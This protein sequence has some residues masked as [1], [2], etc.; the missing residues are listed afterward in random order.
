[1]ERYSNR[2]QPKADD[3]ETKASRKHRFQ[4][5]ATHE[6]EDAIGFLPLFLTR[7]MTK[8]GHFHMEKA[9]WNI[10]FLFYFAPYLH[11][12]AMRLLSWSSENIE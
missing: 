3:E 10:F 11:K 2:V 5:I 9:D 12:F 7:P 8:T 1:M 4:V 6:S